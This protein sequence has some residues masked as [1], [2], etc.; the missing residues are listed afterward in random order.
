[1]KCTV[2]DEESSNEDFCL[3]HTKAHNN[4]VKA[5]DKW[6]HASEV[7]WKEYLSEISKNSFTGQWVKEVAEYLTRKSGK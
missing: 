2:C 5:Y 4:I 7:S 3:I 6:K 1:M